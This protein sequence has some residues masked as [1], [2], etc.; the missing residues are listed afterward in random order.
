MYANRILLGP[1]A[2]TGIQAEI[3]EYLG[4]L[5]KG[6]RRAPWPEPQGREEEG[7]RGKREG[8]GEWQLPP[9]AFT[10]LLAPFG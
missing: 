3:P 5:K 9:P 8:R 4:P 6:R 2:R 10:C 1:N 7:G